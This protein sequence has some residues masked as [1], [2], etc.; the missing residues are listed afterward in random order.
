M[1]LWNFKEE[2]KNRHWMAWTEVCCPKEK[3]ILG[4]WSLFDMYQALYAKLWWNFQTK[5]SLQAKF[6]WITYV[7]RIDLKL[8]NG[9]EVHKFGIT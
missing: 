2:E 8:M 3:G 5:K 9:E 7:K 6:M 4:F 1:F